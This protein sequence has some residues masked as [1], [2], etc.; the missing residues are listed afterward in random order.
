MKLPLQQFLLKSEDLDTIFKRKFLTALLLE[1]KM[2][3][4]DWLKAVTRYLLTGLIAQFLGGLN[5][6]LG[7]IACKVFDTYLITISR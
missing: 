1:N 4:F 3:F 7:W 6:L 5:F 2:E